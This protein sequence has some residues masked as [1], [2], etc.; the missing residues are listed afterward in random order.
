MTTKLGTVS[1]TLPFSLCYIPVSRTFCSSFSYALQC[2]LCADSAALVSPTLHKPPGAPQPDCT[3]TLS[4]YPRWL[5][6]WEFFDGICEL[7]RGIPLRGDIPVVAFRFSHGSDMR[8]LEWVS[9]SVITVSNTKAGRTSL[10]GGWLDSY[11]AHTKGYTWSRATCFSLPQRIMVTV[12]NANTL[13]LAL[14]TDPG[15]DRKL[16]PT[17]LLLSHHT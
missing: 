16:V 9:I 10:S 14:F 11:F 1:S 8:H 5:I 2:S 13:T 12:Y 6:S 3:D 17:N 4:I 7:Q 15:R